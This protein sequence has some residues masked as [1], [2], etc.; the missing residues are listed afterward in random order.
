MFRE[1]AREAGLSDRAPIPRGRGDLEANLRAREALESEADRLGE[2]KASLLRSA[3]RRIEDFGRDLGELARQGNS[4][5]L[6]SPE[7]LEWRIVERA[8]SLPVAE[9]RS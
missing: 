3:A 9:R 1:L 6:F 7:S 2:P 8:L 4:R 5:L